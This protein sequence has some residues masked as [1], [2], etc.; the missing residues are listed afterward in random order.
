MSAAGGSGSSA[1]R[2]VPMAELI[3]ASQQASRATG[4]G[5]RRHGDDQVTLHVLLQAMLGSRVTVEY[6]DDCVA[7]GTLTQVD[8]R[9]KCVRAYCHSCFYNCKNEGL[10]LRA[11]AASA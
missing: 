7:H 9:M 1:Y 5:K 6:R 10:T 11:L 3:A 4:K 8:D 2:D